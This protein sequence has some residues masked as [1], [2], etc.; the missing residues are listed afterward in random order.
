MKKEKTSYTRIEGKENIDKLA[1][2]LR[3][4]TKRNKNPGHINYKIHH[5]LHDPFTFVNAYTKIS[6]NRGA[7]TEGYND[8]GVM[9][10]F[11]LETATSIAKKIKNNTYKFKPVKRNWI[12]KPGKTKKRPIDVP[13]Q[14]NRIVQEAIRGILEAIYEPEFEKWGKDTKHLSNNYGYRPGKSTWSA[15][16]T[17]KEKSQRCTIA[18][19][20][21]IV[22]AY[23]NVDHDILISILKKR[24]KDKKFLN[25]IKQLLKCGV[26]DGHQYEHSIIGT[27]QG[28]IVSPLLFNIY[29]F[30]FDQFV[31]DEI[32]LPI[33]NAEKGKRGD[34]ANKA[35]RRARSQTDKSMKELQE[36]KKKLK[37]QFDPQ[38]KS[39]L[40]LALKDFKRKRS[41]RNTTPYGNVERLEKKA[42]YVRYADDW[43]LTLT[44]NKNEAEVIKQKIAKYLETHRNMRLDKE[45]TKIT[46]IV[47]GYHFLGFEIRKMKAGVKQMFVLQKSAGGKIQRPLKRTTSGQLT[48]EPHSD[49]IL[50][51]LKQNQFC[52]NKYEPR[53]KPGWLVYEEYDIVEKYSQ[54][55]RGIYNYYLP[56]ERLTR[57]NRISYILQYSCGRTLARKRDTTLKK[58][59]TRYGKNFVINKTIKNTKGTDIIR[60]AKFLT[61]T[62]LRKPQPNYKPVEEGSDPF[63]IHQYWRTKMKI[64]NECCLCGETK[65]VVLHHL[66]SVRNLKETSKK[67]SHQRIRST[68][69]RIQI[70]VCHNCHKKITYGQYDDPKRPIK[71]FNEFLAKL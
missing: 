17:L 20:G 39:D 33:I 44:C 59:M 52:N 46:H 11:G 21:D 54:I 71:F 25:L 53:A 5:L 18:I 43:V 47:N 15:L 51:R 27:P 29:M 31:Y 4:H 58:V 67:N 42:V 13:T 63:R 61:L 14:S 8:E 3:E 35:Y 40:K 62:D 56:C 64:Y 19:E 34:D 23:N 30:C 55:F 49:R 60:T 9:K 68:I 26:M 48:I 69:G 32:I 36:L 10:L 7:L 12:P 16:Q 66:N 50:T 41:I 24:I 38:T 45:K 28:G 57:L 65:G 37:T 22:S 70:P 1:F 2:R 6:K